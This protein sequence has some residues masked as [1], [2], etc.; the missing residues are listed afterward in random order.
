MHYCGV[1]PLPRTSS[2]QTASITC[3]HL[4]HTSD[5]PDVA[6][7]SIIGG[8]LTTCRSLAEEAAGLVLRRLQVPVRRNSRDRIIPGGEEFPGSPAEV[9][10]EQSRLATQLQFTTSQV[11]AVWQLCGTRT[12][13][14]LSPTS[15]GEADDDGRKNLS[16]TD[17]PL[18]FVRRVLRDEW[19]CQL[20]DLVERRLM[21]LYWPDLSRACL[22]SW[23][24]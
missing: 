2:S 23:R 12:S 11:A 9:A 1:R 21:L 19:C 17:L 6:I 16:D 10:A 18:R 20:E 4:L 14:M 5:D 13:A 7:V 8:K 22:A 3:R 15:P 24:N